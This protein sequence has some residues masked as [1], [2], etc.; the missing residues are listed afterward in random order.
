MSGGAWGEAEG[1][2]RDAR[3]T[4]SCLCIHDLSKAVEQLLGYI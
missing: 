4:V 3:L 2:V 1:K